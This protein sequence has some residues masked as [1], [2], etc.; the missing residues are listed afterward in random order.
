MLVIKL[1]GS[2]MKIE[3]SVNITYFVHGTTVD[4]EKHV[5]S[6]WADIELSEL[7]KNQ[8]IELKELIGDKKFDVV[9]CSDLKRAVD[10]AK[11][12]FGDKVKIIKDK[13]LRE[14]DYGDFTRVDSEKVDKLYLANID[15]PFPNGESLKDV[16]R[17]IKSFL[18][19]LFIKYSGKKVVIVAHRSPQL[20]LDVILKGKT[21]KQAVE[22]DWRLKGHDGWKPGWEYLLKS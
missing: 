1:V 16:E 2:N 22:E 15:K 3:K 10:S 17:R 20:A 5:S 4:N 9:F 14:C 12:T 21:W 8:S 13:R 7:G 18:N 6:G 19:D 11:L